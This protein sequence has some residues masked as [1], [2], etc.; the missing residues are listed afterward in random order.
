MPCPWP[1]GRLIHNDLPTANDVSHEPKTAQTSPT[2]TITEVRDKE[3]VSGDAGVQ[4]IA[5]IDAGLR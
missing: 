3:I 4:E 1:F 5:P 2:V